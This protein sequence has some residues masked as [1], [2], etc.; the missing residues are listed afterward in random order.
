MIPIRVRQVVLEHAGVLQEA[1]PA[2]LEVAVETLEARIQERKSNSEN[3]A[4]S[5]ERRAR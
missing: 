2:D 1:T 5:R 3:Y 4:R